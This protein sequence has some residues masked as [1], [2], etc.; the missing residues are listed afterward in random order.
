[1]TTFFVVYSVILLALMSTLVGTLAS[2]ASDELK[3][4]ITIATLIPIVI[5]GAIAGAVA[6]GAIGV[7]AS[8]PIF[9]VVGVVGFVLITIT[10][11]HVR[12]Y[13]M[14]AVAQEWTADDQLQEDLCETRYI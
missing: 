12:A 7:P 13:E 5:L 1:M 4:R 3:A 6:A 10:V 2:K 9:L 11:L 8:N 14:G